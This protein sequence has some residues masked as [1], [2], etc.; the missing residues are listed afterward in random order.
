MT[1]PDNIPTPEEQFDFFC[2]VWEADPE[3]EKKEQEER[4]KKKKTEKTD[5]DKAE[6][7]TEQV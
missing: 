5:E 2:R 3:Q 4:Q 6:D 1:Q 7:E